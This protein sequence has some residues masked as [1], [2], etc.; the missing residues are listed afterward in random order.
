VR[1]AI[2]LAAAFAI[3]PAFSQEIPKRVSLAE[4]IRLAQQNSPM[5]GAAKSDA[6]A[7]MAGARAARAGLSPQISANGF[8]TTGN[9][10]SILNSPPMVEPAAWMLIPTGNFLDGNLSLM[11]PIVAPRLNSMANSASWQAKASAGEL[12][13]AQADLT[14]QVTEAYERVL[15]SRQMV[16]AEEAKVTA[17]QEL[18]R[19]TQALFESGKGIEASVQ[20]TQAELSH[21]QRALTSARNEEGKALIDLAASIGDLSLRID[22]SDDLKLA[23]LTSK[24]GDYLTRARESRG[25]LLAAKARR[26]AAASDIRAAEGQ[27]LPQLY[28]AVMGDATNRR[29][30]GGLTAGLTL[31]FPLFDGGRISAEVSQARSMKAKAEAG[32][33]LAELT[34]EKE[35]RQAWLDVQSAQANAVS[36]EASMKAAQSA[37]DV[38]ALRVSAGKSILLEQLDALEALIRAKADLAQ[39]TFDQV[40]AV[41]RLNLAAGGQQ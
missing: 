25:M 37:Y 20:R 12:A 26:E 29:D 28:G 30:M 27:R 15:L 33:K 34:V 4:A 2:L 13:E 41:V 19:T 9:N 14:L 36:A 1:N 8:A 38:T 32:L 22:P 17:T 40:L 24:L 3:S 21:A 7:A 6:D 18:V 16:L 39:A 35:V 31:S 23:V 11:V 5:L 10:S